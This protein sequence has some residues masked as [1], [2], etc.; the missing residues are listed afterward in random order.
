[1]TC[2][3]AVIA[4]P[5]SYAI[6][7]PPDDAPP[8]RV[9]VSELPPEPR[10]E[11][12]AGRAREEM[13]APEG[14]QA[15]FLG[16]SVVE[17]P[18]LLAAH[19]ELPN[20]EGALVRMVTP[21][22]AAEKA[23][24]R[25]HDVLLKVAGMP[26][27]GHPGLAEIVAKRQAGDTV[28]LE[29]MRKGET[30]QLKAVLDARPADL[31]VAPGPG[32]DD[33]FLQDLPQDQAGRIREMIE[34][35][36]R[37]MRDPGG[38]LEDDVFQ[39]AF[40][41][42][43]EQMEQLLV[44]PDPFAQPDDDEGFGRLKM[45]VGATVRLMDKEGSVEIKSVDGGKEVVV[46]DVENKIMWAGPWDTEQDKA[47]APDDVRTRIERLNIDGFQQGNGLQFRMFRDR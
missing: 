9:E 6:Q 41:G 11:P 36:L 29:V 2:L 44:E 3:A 42:M 39:D 8:P 23:G 27:A 40:R 18:D 37:A 16:V 20:G 15:G 17:V 33:R 4:A 14:E 28:E 47:A 45:N 21:G 19:L 25:M 26:V 34:Q 1:M 35:N 43:R 10:A 5:T 32:F 30:H 31:Q 12:D 38:L 24:V 22:S 46:R 7:P 13:P